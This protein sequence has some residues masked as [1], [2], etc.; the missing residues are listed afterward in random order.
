ML[1]CIVYR[2]RLVICRR[3]SFRLYLLS[4]NRVRQANPLPTC[5]ETVGRTPPIAASWHP[6]TAA[7]CQ[8]VGFNNNKKHLR[9]VSYNFIC[10]QINQLVLYDSTLNACVDHRGTMADWMMASLFSRNVATVAHILSSSFAALATSF[11]N[12]E[13]KIQTMESLWGDYK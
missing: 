9:G 12:V 8:H 11:Y 3:R 2:Q 13:I 10:R 6:V 7:T 5:R 4:Q 1:Q